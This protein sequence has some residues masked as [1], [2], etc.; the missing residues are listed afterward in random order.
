MT[1]KWQGSLLAQH[2]CLYWGSCRTSSRGSSWTVRS[3]QVLRQE[4]GGH[5]RRKRWASRSAASAP[6][7]GSC[8]K[9]LQRLKCRGKCIYFD[10][11]ASKTI[12]TPIVLRGKSYCGQQSKKTISMGLCWL[13]KSNSKSTFPPGRGGQWAMLICLAVCI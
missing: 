5:R 1:G 12:L 13:W 2:L 11:S 7:T 4:A 3:E 9:G 6:H 8:G 10:G